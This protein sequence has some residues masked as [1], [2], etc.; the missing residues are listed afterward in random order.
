MIRPRSISGSAF[1]VLCGLSLLLSLTFLIMWPF[2]YGFY[3]SFG[4]DTDRADGAYVMSAYYRIRWPGNGSVWIG[5]GAFRH[6]FEGKPL[7]PFDL[8][9]SFFLAPRRPPPQSIW[10]RMG[11]WLL[12]IVSDD[13]PNGKTQSTANQWQ[14]W[15]GVPSW[16]PVFLTGVLPVEWW[17]K[18]TRRR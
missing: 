2:S 18:K 15:I 12:P 6:P 16:L 10:N 14:F 5:G 9:G 4:V 13:R 8:G 3:T 7:E 11:F 1:S 17:K